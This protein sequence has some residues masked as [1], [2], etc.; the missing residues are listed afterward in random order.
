MEAFGALA[1][2]V[3]HDFNNL[4]T[5]I[6]GEAEVALLSAKAPE[7]RQPLEAIVETS[8]RTVALT[9]QLLTFTRRRAFRLR[10]VDLNELAGSMTRLLRRLLRDDISLTMNLTAGQLPVRIDAGQI[11]QVLVN[12]VINAGEAIEGGGTVTVSTR[13]STLPAGPDDEGG[14]RQAV[15]LVVED[16]GPGIA[17]D[18]LPEI[19]EPFFTTKEQGTGLGL[20]TCRD[21]VL[22]SGG[23]LTASSEPSGSSFVVSL[24]AELS[25]K[26]VRLTG[27]VEP[28]QRIG[29]DSRVLVV[30]DERA[31]GD[32]VGR[33][34]Q[35]LGHDVEVVI[36]RSAALQ[37][38]SEVPRVDVIVCDM[39]MPGLT[40]AD[41]VTQLAAQTPSLP[42]LLMSGDPDST[43]TPELRALAS[44]PIAFIAKPFNAAQLVAAVRALRE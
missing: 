7:Q 19:F 22:K 2:G 16:D 30:D 12:L 23:D 26:P 20:A 34:L 36:T 21:I 42:V 10:V 8:M 13:H 18:V 25:D 24:P 44:A 17:A 40:L 6:I 11:E 9:R 38:A 5:A 41:F 4:L 33:Q 39:R 3:A 27:V 37:R 43:I 31:V 28:A 35:A 1:G 14:P 32:S 29:A 15:D